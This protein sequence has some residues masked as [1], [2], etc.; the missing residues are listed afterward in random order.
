M[1]LISTFM[2]YIETLQRSLSAIDAHPGKVWEP[3]TTS[4]LHHA[5]QSAMK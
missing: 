3:K 2:I 5:S 4:L 1:E